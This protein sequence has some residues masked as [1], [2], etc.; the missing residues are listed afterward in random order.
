MYG[1]ALGQISS[2]QNFKEALA[3]GQDALWASSVTP[4]NVGPKGQLTQI[5][6]SIGVES[7]R[8]LSFMTNYSAA[9]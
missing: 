7:Q 1:W 3:E 4:Q 9:T 6:S 2:D 8:L 5:N